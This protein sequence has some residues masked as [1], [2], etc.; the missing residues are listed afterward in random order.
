MAGLLIVD[1]AAERVA[2]QALLEQTVAFRYTNNHQQRK[3]RT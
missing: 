2:L 1:L 3:V